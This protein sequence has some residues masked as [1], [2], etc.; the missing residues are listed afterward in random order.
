M[1]AT[2]LFLWAE[3]SERELNLELAQAFP[4]ARIEQIHSRLLQLTSEMS[5]DLRLPCLV[6]SRQ[7]LPFTRTIR[8]ESIRIWASE[9]TGVIIESLPANQPWV[10]HIEP[11]YGVRSTQ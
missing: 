4:G 10:L 9:V 8:A 6:F 11:H 3:D 1:S 5:L 2:H 7:F